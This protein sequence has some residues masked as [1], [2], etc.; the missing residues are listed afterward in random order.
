M[1]KIVALALLVFVTPSL[2]LAQDATIRFNV[3]NATIVRDAII[4]A[5][6]WALALAAVA[7][8]RPPQQRSWARRHPALLGAILGSAALVGTYVAI[9]AKNGGFCDSGLYEVPCPLII[10]GYGI[11]GASFGA[12]IGLVIF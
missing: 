5:D 10:T 11:A 3:A 6:R 4:A 1:Q 2:A 9:T 7:K 12:V 8:Q